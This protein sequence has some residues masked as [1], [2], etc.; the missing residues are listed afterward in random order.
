MISNYL[1]D[2]SVLIGLLKREADL[3]HRTA[4]AD[5]TIYI[6]SIALG[7]LY[8]GAKCSTQTVN[9]ISSLQALTLKLPLLS[10]DAITAVN[11]G[12]IKHEQRQIGKM[13]PDNDIW[14][15]AIA[16][17]YG[18]ILITRDQHFTWVLKLRVEQW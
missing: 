17:Q 10:V 15:A 5:S 12:D 13:I 3:L 8:Y 1:L 11:Y 4:I 14:I 6:P 9:E 2:T 18:L 16:R 7:E